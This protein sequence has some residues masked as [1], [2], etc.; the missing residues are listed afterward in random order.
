VLV[1]LAACARPFAPPGGDPD[2]LP[3]GL[4]STSPAPFAVLTEL[5]EPVV[6]RF[7][8]RIRTRNFSPALVS[9]SPGVPEDVEFQVKGNEVRVGLRGG[10]RQGQIYNVVIRPGV[11]DMF[12]NRRARAAELVF[13]T[14]PQV[15][16]SVLAGLIEDRLTGRPAREAVEAV[17][18]TDSTVPSAG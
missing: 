11:E 6:F 15:P 14:G 16:H 12:N 9:V 7:D 4:V 17:R 3:P 1:V 18:R 5:D 10:W 8:E 13:T 2:R